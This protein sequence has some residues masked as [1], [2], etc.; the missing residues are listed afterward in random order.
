MREKG[1]AHTTT[2]EIAQQASCSEGALYRHFGSKE[3]LFL[4]VLHERL[5]GLFQ[6]MRDLPAQVGLG[7][8]QLTLEQVATVALAFYDRSVPIAVSVFTDPQLAERHQEALGDDLGPQRPQEILATYLGAE[9]RIGR[10]AETSDPDSVAALLLGACFQR[11]F[12]GRY[13]GRD[14]EMDDRFVRAIV[15]TLLGTLGSADGPHPALT[16]GAGPG[17]GGVR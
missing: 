15:A 8:V 7:T 12:F 10:V 6:L 4:A 14:A 11:A 13:L 16:G 1:L 5:P 17:E 9:R 2:K 3:D